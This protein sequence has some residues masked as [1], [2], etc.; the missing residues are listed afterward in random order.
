M[1]STSSPLLRSAFSASSQPWHPKPEHKL[2]VKFLLEHACAGLFLDPGLGKTS[3]VLAAL[4]ILFKKRL[5]NKVLVIAPRRVCYLVWP[6]EQQKWTDFHGLRM[7]VLHGPDKDE[8]L[9]ADADIYVINPEGLE[10]LIQP[11]KTKGP[12]GKTKVTVNMRRWK[13][14]GFDVLVVDELT[15][16][17]HT[18]SD[19]FKMIKEILPTFGRRWGLTGSPVANGLMQLFGQ[20]YVLDQGRSL[21]RYITH[22]RKQ[23]FDQGYNSFTYTLKPGA[24]K[25]IF[26]RIRPL[27][28]RLAA[29]DYVKLPK[30][31]LNDIKVDLPDSVRALYAKLEDDLI[32]RV[33]DKVVTAAN[34]GVASMKC[35]QLA[36]GGI[37]LDHEIKQLVKLP[38]A[39]REWVDLHEEKVDAVEEL[40]EELQGA[41]LL[42]AYDFK[43]DLHRLQKRL[44]KDAPHIGSGVSEKRTKELEQLWNQ[45]QF[46]FMLAQWESL[47]HGL[48]LQYSG[49]ETNHVCCHSLTYNR[50]TYEQFIQRLRRRGNVAKR[51]FVHHLIARGTVDEVIMATLQAKDRTQ[52]AFFTALQAYARRK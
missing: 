6:A 30:L 34:A 35:R 31:I 26:A 45:G 1:K 39:T 43:H 27:A 41:P 20:C 4:K 8:L 23:F 48:N 2:S 29:K 28:L 47:A 12:S 42:I 33:N 37:Y 25:K 44:G 36:N 14:L 51:V 24:D 7:V 18:S 50:E 9:R 52:Q 16:F 11:I 10:W 49:H 46:P 3:S 32:V 13:A 17:K 5:I 40:I 21:G 38:K 15:K 19:R 22:Y